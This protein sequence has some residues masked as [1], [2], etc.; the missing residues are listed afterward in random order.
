MT[1][2]TEMI[3]N[4][5][6][7]YEDITVLGPSLEYRLPN[8]I[9]IKINNLGK[10]NRNLVRMLNKKKIYVSIGSA[11]QTE[12]KESHVLNTIGITDK[13]DKIKVIRISLSDYTTQDEVEYLITN[14]VLAIKEIH[15]K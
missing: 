14:L 2:L 3:I 4:G 15:K 13:K 6:S 8:T 1:E 7:K 11:C 9:L 5:V 12:Q 10:C